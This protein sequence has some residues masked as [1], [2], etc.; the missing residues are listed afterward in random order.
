ME[1]EKRYNGR[2]E[3]RKRRLDRMKRK[4]KGGRRKYW[5]ERRRTG[6]E[7]AGQWKIGK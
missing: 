2:E 3:V 4:W 7:R 6:E 5:E 1:L